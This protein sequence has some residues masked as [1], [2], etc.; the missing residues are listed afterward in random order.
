MKIAVKEVIVK[1]RVRHDIGDISSLMQS[2]RDHGQLNPITVDRANELIAGHRRLLAAREL[3]WTYIDAKIVDKSSEADR[4]E[5]ELEENV[6]RKDFLPEELL[7][8]YRKLEKLRR[9]RLTRRI[10]NFFRNFFSKLFRRKKKEAAVPEN[11]TDTTSPREEH[12]TKNENEV[13]QFGV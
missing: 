13:E 4:L 8:G 1:E 5:L 10:G 9:P 6:H 2:M 3:G 11:A 7:A 12:P